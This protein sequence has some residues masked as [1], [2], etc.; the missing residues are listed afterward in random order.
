M[1]DLLLVPLVDFDFVRVLLS[2][3]IGLVQ[4]PPS[5]LRECANRNGD[6]RALAH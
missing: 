6:L 3:V 1:A 2:H 5:L 4:I